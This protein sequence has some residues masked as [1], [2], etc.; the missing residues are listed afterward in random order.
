MSHEL[1]E[2]L[3]QAGKAGF[4]W[5]EFRRTDS[6][7][8]DVLAGLL[9]RGEATDVLVLHRDDIAHA[10]RTP[11]AQAEDVFR[12][13]QVFWW[14]GG[15]PEL[16]VGTLLALPAPDASGAPHRLV[17]VPVPSGVAGELTPVRVRVPL[18]QSA[19]HIGHPRVSGA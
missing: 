17:P 6:S 14:F 9:H 7:R 10:Y 12:P 11:T 19:R 15:P 5:W 4:S 2:L 3:E 8:P 18:W 1:Q 16:T 13:D